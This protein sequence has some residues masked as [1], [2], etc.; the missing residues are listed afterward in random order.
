MAKRSGTIVRAS[1]G[2]LLGISL[3]ALSCACT[4]VEIPVATRPP[5]DVVERA[6]PPLETHDHLGR[7]VSLDRA[8]E[9]GP[10]A[11]V[12]YRGFW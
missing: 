5:A 11:L 1:L 7:A 2:G 8:L 3:G 12:F 6:A 4:L 9:R 10:V